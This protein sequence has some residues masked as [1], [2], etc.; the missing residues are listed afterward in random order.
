VD[1]AGC[2]RRWR[3]LRHPALVC[4]RATCPRL[5]LGLPCLATAARWQMSNEQ[6]RSSA[7]VQAHRLLAVLTAGSLAVVTQA[8]EFEEHPGKYCGHDSDLDKEHNCGELRSAPSP[9][10]C[11]A[12]WSDSDTLEQCKD[13]CVKLQCPCLGYLATDTGY[14][15]KCRIVNPDGYSG[16]LFR[17]STGFLAV[18]TSGAFPL[19]TD[20]RQGW[21]GWVVVGAALAYVLGGFAHGHVVRGKRRWEAL[22]HI[23][24]WRALLALAKDGAAFSRSKVLSPKAAQSDIRAPLRSP[25]RADRKGVVE[26]KRGADKADSDKKKSKKGKKQRDPKRNKDPEEASGGIGGSSHQVPPDATTATP[27]SQGLVERREGDVHTSQ[28]R[29]QVVSLLAG[30]DVS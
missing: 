21:V 29:V 28:Q 2:S 13:Q 20:P 4:Q 24:R 17:S 18:T 22:P 12:Y 11:W 25:D 7:P 5:R 6:Q 26:R 3:Y 19:L 16:K 23:D 10:P 14:F 27:T 15:H 1:A 30:S 9:N 8:V